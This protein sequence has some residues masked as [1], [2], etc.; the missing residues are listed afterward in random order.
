MNNKATE[1]ILVKSSPT[2]SSKLCSSN[3][4]YKE[5]HEGYKTIFKP[6]SGEQKSLRDCLSKVPFYKREVLAY[7]LDKLLGFNLVPPTVVATKIIE[8]KKRGKTK[9]IGSR[10]LWVNGIEGGNYS[11]RIEQLKKIKTFKEQLIKMFVF[12]VICLNTDRHAGNYIVDKKTESLYAI[13]N[14]LSFP[15]KRKADDLNCHPFSTYDYGLYQKIREEK[16]YLLNSIMNKKIISLLKKVKKSDFLSLFKKFSLFK[17]G[18]QAWGRLS[19]L[20]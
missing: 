12:D 8:T 18:Q 7:E 19:Q 9:I 10:Q 20:I 11:V 1:K 5:V 15:E 6:E 17:E 16:F 2:K 13:D 3:T 14:A 4:A